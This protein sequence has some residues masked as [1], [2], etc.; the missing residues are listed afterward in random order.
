M[1][2]VVLGM[3]KSGTTLVTEMLHHSGIDMVEA[4]QS[5]SY[6][7]GAYYERQ[8]TYALN[9][10]LL[11]WDDENLLLRPGSGDLKLS[12]VHQARMQAII[13][14]N[15][16]QHAD[17]G[18]KDPR[19]CLT[20]RLWEAALGE[21][22][23]IVV[24]RPLEAIWHRYQYR[25]L[26]FWK[27]GQRAWELVRAWCAYNRSILQIL[28]TT[29]QASIV[30]RYDRLLD[31]DEREFKRLEAFVQR[32]LVDRRK[33]SPKDRSGFYPTLELAGWFHQAMKRE[34]VAQLVQ[35]LESLREA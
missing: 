22:R 29:T 18:F 16:Q 32:P 3:H 17:W 25:G 5:G 19:T 26:R 12:L 13:S 35:S 9:L 27:H 20:Y 8:S 21:H 28:Q 6:E 4:P 24:F 33:P 7:Q 1:I 10:A 11:G 23:L 30:I 14:E 2:Y 31:T 34:S 15:N